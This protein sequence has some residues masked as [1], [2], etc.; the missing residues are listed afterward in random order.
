MN[1]AV[2]ALVVAVIVIAY[3]IWF[4]RFAHDKGPHRNADG[5]IVETSTMEPFVRFF[6]EWFSRR[7]T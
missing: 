2:P 1:Y 5:R 7:R 4:Y 3:L 6:R